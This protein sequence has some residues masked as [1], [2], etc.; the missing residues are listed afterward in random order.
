MFCA[1]LAFI[2]SDDSQ[3]DAVFHIKK[4]IVFCFAGNKELCTGSD[5]FGYEESSASSAQRDL[6]DFSSRKVRMTERVQFQ[7]LFDAL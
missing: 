2:V 5:R 3:Q 7:C 4:I 6:A 1:S